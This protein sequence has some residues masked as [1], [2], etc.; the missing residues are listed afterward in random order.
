MVPGAAARDHLL[1][2]LIF[3]RD[4]HLLDV[5][6]LYGPT[7]G[8]VSRYLSAKRAWLRDLPGMRHTLLTVGPAGVGPDGELRLPGIR[9]PFTAPL[10]WPAPARKWID[11]MRTL[12]PDVIEVSDLGPAAWYALDAARERDT[13]VLAFAHVDLPRFAEER[14]GAVAAAIVRFYCRTVYRQCHVVVAPS[15]YVRRRL[16]AMGVERVV[17]RH[18]GVAAGTFH[19]SRQSD[20]LRRRLEVDARTRVLVYAGRFAAEK[21]IDVLLDAFR[22]LGSRYR[23]VLV[24]SGD[25]PALP[26]N[27]VRLPFLADAGA[28][29]DVLAGADALVHAGDVE[30]FGLVYLEAMACGRPVVCADG[31]AAREIVTPAC[32]ERAQPGSA[33]ALAAAVGALYARDIEAVGLAARRRIDEHFT[34]DHSMQRLLALYRTTR[35]APVTTLPVLVAS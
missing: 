10:R 14:R 5:T 29:A 19:P 22:V 30:T 8:G 33:E 12:A 20:A 35:A 32:G 13:P 7:V 9:V 26:D 34:L 25:T 24:G 21:R 17:V 27:V 11:A 3:S 6:Q 15:E 18:L 16:E 4:M 28:L 31:G 1:P 2:R 23:L